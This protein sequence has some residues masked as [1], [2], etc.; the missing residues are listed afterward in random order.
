MNRKIAKSRWNLTLWAFHQST[1]PAIIISIK[2][3]MDK[4]MARPEE[5]KK[6]LNSEKLQHFYILM[7]NFGLKLIRRI[8]YGRT[9]S[10]IFILLWYHWLPNILFAHNSVYA[11]THIHIKQ[12]EKYK[13]E[14]DFDEKINQFFQ[15]RWCYSENRKLF[16]LNVVLDW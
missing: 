2:I 9:S 3:V 11:L 15:S 13:C 1:S 12:M 5:R 10:L 6:A 8:A 14:N 16:W 4:D 7:I